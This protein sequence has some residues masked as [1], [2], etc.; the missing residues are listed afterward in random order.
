M[1]ATRTIE[2]VVTAETEAEAKLLAM[3]SFGDSGDNVKVMADETDSS[4]QDISN[5]RISTPKE[6][7]Q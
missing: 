5:R 3:D 6:I 4:D 2:M 7:K 1:P